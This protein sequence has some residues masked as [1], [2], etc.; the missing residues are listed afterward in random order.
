MEYVFQV[1]RF[2]AQE[3]IAN[4]NCD[5]HLKFIVHFNDLCNHKTKVQSKI[6]HC[7]ERDIERETDR[8]EVEWKK[9]K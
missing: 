5:R 6:M 1:F 8:E 3:M 4:L 7:K 2:G 9:E